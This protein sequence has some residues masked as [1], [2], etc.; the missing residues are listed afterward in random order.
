MSGR[1]F[2][3]TTP[4]STMD[5]FEGC[6]PSCQTL[7]QPER[8]FSSFF[9]YPPVPR[10]LTARPSVPPFT[11]FSNPIPS[12]HSHLVFEVNFFFSFVLLHSL[13]CFPR[14][15]LFCFFFPRLAGQFLMTVQCQTFVPPTLY[16][17][18]LYF[19]STKPPPGLSPHITAWHMFAFVLPVFSWRKNPP[20]TPLLCEPLCLSIGGGHFPVFN[21]LHTCQPRISPP[22]SCGLF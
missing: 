1:W 17:F 7:S 22:T 21:P 12:H 19:F 5:F 6:H 18:F 16:N 10:F 9:F 3:S 2:I 20:D 11:C 13:Y 15:A 4:F 8:Y 14:W